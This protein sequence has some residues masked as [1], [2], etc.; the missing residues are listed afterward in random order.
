MASAS[1]ISA[2]L[3]NRNLPMVP[4]RKASDGV[5][6]RKRTGEW[7]NPDV[8]EVWV[9]YFNAERRA[10]MIAAVHTVLDDSPWTYEATPWGARITGT[11]AIATLPTETPEPQTR[12]AKR[13]IIRDMLSTHRRVP[14]GPEPDRTPVTAAARRAA[15]ESLRPATKTQRDKIRTLAAKR[16]ATQPDLTS[17]ALAVVE[18]ATRDYAADIITRLQATPE[19]DAPAMPPGRY[20]YTVHGRAANRMTHVT[21]AGVAID[22]DSNKPLQA[23]DVRD[24][25][26]I[27]AEPA[28][29][30]RAAAAFGRITGICGRCGRELDNPASLKRGLGPD[31]KDAWGPW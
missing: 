12:A 10:D 30:R 4:Y 13:A 3:R 6:V 2:Y 7:G 25:M 17:E 16:I 24:M 27:L 8:I 19:D 21:D 23:E 14:S 22:V 20:V 31:C 5:S 29:A 26:M 11:R 1:G 28:D 18:Q 15:R 9:I